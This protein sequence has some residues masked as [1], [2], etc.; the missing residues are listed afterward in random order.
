MVVA[1]RAGGEEGD[2]DRM[3]AAAGKQAARGDDEGRTSGAGQ[4]ADVRPL[5]IERA[6]RRRARAEGDVAGGHLDVL[7]RRPGADR[8]VDGVIGRDHRGVA[9]AAGRRGEVFQELGV[10][11]GPA[12]DERDVGGE[13]AVDD[14]VAGAEADVGGGRTVTRK[15]ERR[16]GIG[17]GEG[18]EADRA[19][20]RSAGVVALVDQRLAADQGERA[21][22]FAPV[23]RILSG[24]GVVEGVV[25]DADARTAGDDRCDVAETIL[26]GGGTGRKQQLQGRVAEREPGDGLIWAGAADGIVVLAANLTEK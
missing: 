26:L 4:G 25:L 18:G 24:G 20:D 23:D 3:P 17:P 7:G 16:R 22:D 21:E 14:L 10:G 15:E 11:V 12:A 6:D 19:H 2:V 5:E 9:E 1:F 8:R 13:A